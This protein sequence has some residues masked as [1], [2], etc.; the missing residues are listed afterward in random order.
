M[1]ADDE[2]SDSSVED[3]SDREVRDILTKEQML[4]ALASM[5]FY[6]DPDAPDEETDEEL[7]VHGEQ[8]EGEKA[9]DAE[10]RRI[11]GFIAERGGLY[12]K[13]LIETFTALMQTHDM[14]V[15]GGRS[16]TG[17]TSFCQRYAEAIGAD[18]T[19]VPVKPNWMST[20]DLLGYFNP[21]NGTYVSTLF[22]DD[23]LQAAAHPEKDASRCARRNEHR[24]SRTLLRGFPQPP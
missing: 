20:E 19:I 22:R 4:D 2:N 7:S 1:A 13:K 15:L 23:L 10:I 21:V 9:W 8:I 17:K 24:D 14:V 18:V 11:E 12:P 16:G 3:A 5:G 6:T